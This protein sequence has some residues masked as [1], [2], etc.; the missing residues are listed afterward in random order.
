[1][2]AQGKLRVWGGPS[3]PVLT[4]LVLLVC[5]GHALLWFGVASPLQVTLSAS[6][7]ARS[8]QLR[9]LPPKAAVSGAFVAPVAVQ[10]PPLA[11][12]APTA[13]LAP[14]EPATPARSEPPLPQ[15]AMPPQEP[16]TAGAR[17]DEPAQAA[18]IPPEAVAGPPEPPSQPPSQPVVGWP[19]LSLGALP[20]SQLLHYQLTGM[21]KGLLYHASG[22]LRWQ[23]N[24]AAYELS[25]S[26]R[27]FLVG[28]RQWRS[29]GQIDATGLAPTRFSDSWRGERATHFDR[30]QQRVVFSSNSTPAALAPGAQDQISLYVQLATAMLGEPERFAP[31]MRL[32]VQTA[33]TR[34][35]TPWSLL[36]EGQE[37]LLIEG[38]RV[39]ASKWLCQPRSQFDARIEFW[40]SAAQG[41][42]PVRIRITQASGS[43]IDLLWRS[44]EPLAPLPI[45][46]KAA[47]A[48][49]PLENRHT[50]ST[51]ISVERS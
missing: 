50:D 14:P 10:A 43:Y 9:V 11:P 18:E 15:Q 44:T 19:L 5:L 7:P 12:I 47:L 27:A 34:D 3:W 24:E 46:D 25:L 49:K 36:L 22:Q 29:V 35:A 1:M 41:W 13:Q 30:E 23:H 8:V 20:P 28:Q 39:M 37:S 21:D 17:A 48:P 33:T 51:W 26:V 42:M 2:A 40:L 6:P 16:R 45:Q 38:Q 4:G 31:G 32:Q